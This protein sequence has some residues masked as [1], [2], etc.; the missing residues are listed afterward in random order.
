MSVVCKELFYN[1]RVRYMKYNS[2]ALLKV[3]YKFKICLKL[4]NF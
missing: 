2:M 1:A 3:T 4:G